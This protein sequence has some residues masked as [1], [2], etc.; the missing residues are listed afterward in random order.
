M[1]LCGFGFVG[2]L[3]KSGQK[4]NPITSIVK[5]KSVTR[6][7]CDSSDRSAWSLVLEWRLGYEH[8]TGES[9]LSQCLFPCAFLSLYKS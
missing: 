2:N 8:S 4:K 7:C 5:R 6:L 9:Q 1:L 3:D